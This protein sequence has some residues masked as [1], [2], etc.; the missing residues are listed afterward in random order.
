[1]LTATQAM[2]DL[3]CRVRILVMR[4]SLALCGVW[5]LSK[6]S[7]GNSF[8]GSADSRRTNNNHSAETKCCN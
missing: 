8:P 5:E 6:E 1:M 2:N 7:T 4:N 3:M